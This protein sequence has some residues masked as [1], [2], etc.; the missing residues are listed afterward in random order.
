MSEVRNRFRANIEIDAPEPFWE[1][2]LFELEEHYVPFKIGNIT[3]AGLNPCQRCI[4]PTRD[5][6]T[7]ASTDSFTKTFIENRKRTLPDW[8]EE[9]RFDHFYKLSVNTK[10]IQAEKDSVIKL[11]DELTL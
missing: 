8:A 2:R 6:A 7:G 4:V 1:D 3:F 9:S 10:I 5:S 11:G